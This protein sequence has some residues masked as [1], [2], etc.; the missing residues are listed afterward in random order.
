MEGPDWLVSILRL[1]LS[2]LLG[3]LIG[4]EREGYGKE[5]GLKI[6]VLVALGATLFTLASYSALGGA[7]GGN[8]DPTRIAAQVV[9]GVGFLGAG[10]I[11]QARGS[12]FGMT[13]AASIWIV[14]AMGT[15]VGLG[16]YRGAL[17]TVGLGGLVLLGL[18]HLERRVVFARPV[19]SRIKA[20][21]PAKADLLSIDEFVRELRIQEV[22]WEASQEGPSTSVLFE[23]FLR[24]G[25]LEAL[26]EKLRER[27]DVSQLSVCRG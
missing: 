7:G 10:A 16:F 12:V 18:P 9:T 5:A 26:L 27:G 6:S 20:R 23:G 1:G 25:Q 8:V 3:A 13:T 19:L 22:R 21:L 24:Q 14:A 11:I 15:A 2:V 4:I 17:L